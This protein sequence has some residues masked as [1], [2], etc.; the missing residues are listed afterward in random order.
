[1]NVPFR[2]SGKT[3]L[4]VVFFLV[5]LAAVWGTGETANACMPS[6]TCQVFGSVTPDQNMSDVYVLA[7]Y[8]TTGS[9]D[10]SWAIYSL[11]PLTGG[12]TT[13]FSYDIYGPVDHFGPYTII[14]LYDYASGKVTT[15]MNETAAADVIT[16]H[17]Q[18]TS[19][20]TGHDIESTVAAALKN[21]NPWA[22]TWLAAYGADVGSTLKL[23][24]FTGAIDGGR[25]DLTTHCP[26]P[27]S[28]LLMA[29][30]LGLVLLLRRRKRG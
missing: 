30:S 3:H 29:P 15:G 10:A 12:S 28:L 5:C 13:S 2:R 21:D 27:P 9:S 11:G 8:Y 17:K 25:A 26:P 7:Q 20:F 4:L 1:M 19:V 14:G 18:W 22:F 23:V 24:N 6:A 16:L